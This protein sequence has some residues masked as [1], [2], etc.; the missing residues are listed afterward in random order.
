MNFESEY[1]P[2]MIKRIAKRVTRA[3]T[4]KRYLWEKEPRRCRHISGELDRLILEHK[5]EAVLMF[6][7]EGCAFS[8]TEVPIYCF[9]DS[10]FGS[11]TDL[12]D[13]QKNIS[14]SSVDDGTFVQQLALNRLR[15]LYISSKWALDRAQKKYHYAIDSSKVR[16]IGIGANLP[17]TIYEYHPAPIE[18]GNAGA[19]FVWIGVDWHRKRGQ[20]AIE[21]VT[22]LRQLGIDARLH[23]VGPVNVTVEH[24]WVCA[25][26]SLNYDRS[27]DFARLRRIFER[28]CAMLLPSRADLTPIAIAECYAF[29]RPV[30][31]SGTGAISEM[32]EE[33]QTGLT[34]ASNLAT[35]WASAIVAFFSQR[36]HADI[37]K[38]C[39]TRFTSVYNW[40]LVAQQIAGEII[41]E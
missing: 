1:R 3:V 20:F 2:A 25:H 39:R 40:D 7:S 35:D 36:A 8:K 16:V 41:G 22:A 21:V 9:A 5:P 27:A 37:A 6:G 15:K 4:G 38:S 23:I 19:E 14:R 29:G 11:R 31:A 24:E 18:F 26:G 32:V 28:C 13:D 12:Y 30:F 17:R 34:F 10:I 33:S